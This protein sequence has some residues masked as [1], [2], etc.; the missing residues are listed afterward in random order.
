MALKERM[1]QKHAVDNSIGVVGFVA[2]GFDRRSRWQLDTP[3]AFSRAGCI[4]PSTNHGST[5]CDL[6]NHNLMFPGGA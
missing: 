4:D 1:V 3:A 2:I 5:S 6:S